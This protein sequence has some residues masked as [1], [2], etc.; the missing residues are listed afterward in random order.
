MLLKIQNIFPNQISF[1]TISRPCVKFQ[2]SSTWNTKLTEGWTEWQWTKSHH[3]SS[4]CEQG[5]AKKLGAI[6]SE[7][8]S[9]MPLWKGWIYTCTTNNKRRYTYKENKMYKEK[10]FYKDFRCGGYSYW[11]NFQPFMI[12][13]TFNWCARSSSSVF[14]R[15]TF[16]DVEINYLFI[17]YVPFSDYLLL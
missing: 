16:H 13:D 17:K 7:W 10:M 12:Q 15:D 6:K 2:R 5:W 11:L 14:L 8:T 4:P 9:E 1:M 3:K